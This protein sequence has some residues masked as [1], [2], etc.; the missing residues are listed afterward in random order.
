[1]ECGVYFTDYRADMALRR[2]PA[3]RIRLWL[4]AVG[5][6]VFPFV[7]SP[8]GLTL[9]NQV[10]IATVGAIGSTSWWGTRG[11]SRWGRGPSWRWAPTARA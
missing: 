5:V 7:A 2:K 4:F 9:A 10:A 1:M 3:E 11:R 6:L 8:Y